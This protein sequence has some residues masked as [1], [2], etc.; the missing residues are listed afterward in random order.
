MKAHTHE[1]AM[2]FIRAAHTVTTLSYEEVISVYLRARGILQDGADMLGAP[3][4]RQWE[5]PSDKGT[6][7]LR[8]ATKALRDIQ[9]L[10]HGPDRGSAQWQADSAYGIAAKAQID[11]RDIDNR[12]VGNAT[13]QDPGR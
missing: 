5:P 13:V 12:E 9:G 6:L 7:K 10:G 11:M 2:D 3:I 1:E 8:L 4:P